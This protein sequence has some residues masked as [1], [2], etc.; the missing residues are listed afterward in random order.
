MPELILIRGLPGSGKTTLARHLITTNQM[1]KMSASVNHYEADMFFMVN[2]KYEFD[3]TRLN[4]AHNWCL[5]KTREGVEQGGTVIV[6][7]T[8]TRLR[9]LRPYF[10]LAKEFNIVPVVYLA[11]NT[12]GSVHGVPEETM[13]KMKERFAFDISPLFEEFK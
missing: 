11:Q 12:F 2:E 5:D 4:Q 8:F 6:S 13:D 7:N 1:L 10:E 9:E 3:A